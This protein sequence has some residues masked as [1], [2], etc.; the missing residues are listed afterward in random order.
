V[1]FLWVSNEPRAASGYGSQTRQVG[2]RLI[3][4]GHEIEFSANDGTRGDRTWNGSLVRGSGADR[5]SRDTV[6]EDAIRSG[7]DWV[8]VLYDP[9]VF[10]HQVRDPFAG[11]T[12]VT[13]WTPID[14]M[15]ISP[16][17]IPWLFEHSS[18][19]MS[20]FG[21][22]RLT[23]LDAALQR[24]KGHGFPLTYI[25]HAIE[26]VFRPTDVATFREIAGIPPD[27][28]VVGIVAANTGGLHYDRKGFG[29]MLTAVAPFMERRP[30]VHLYLHTLAEGHEG[31][32][33][34]VLLNVAGI[35]RARVHWAD[36]YRYKKQD[37]G[38]EE[39]AAIYSSLDVLLA[40]SHG[41]GFG[42]PV[43]EAQACG[44][45]VIVSNCT[46]QPELVG[47][48]WA[49]DRPQARRE[50]S[51]WV[52]ATQPDW[53]AKHGS[54]FAR[55]DIAQITLALEDARTRRGDPEM[56]AAAIAKA[57][58]YDADLVFDTYW[59]PYLAGLETSISKLERAKDRRV[60]R[61]G[62]RRAA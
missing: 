39:M 3:A 54:W 20:R 41:E 43:I 12:N 24:D 4:A 17:L 31:L 34:P 47:E 35:D 6:R 59:R 23:E 13:C 9:W 61:N 49:A 32:N 5:Y 26:R 51:G 58:E 37:I 29:D 57:A 2:H 56:R 46:A 25:P 44:V 19:A 55:P 30:D 22:D 50:P 27:A 52:I 21:F 14:H 1:K 53:N 33:L 60:R 28:F 40:T 18:I 10:T 16:A 11:M 36:P 42:L 62:K 7:A 8:I 38:D 48:V 45:P 15:P